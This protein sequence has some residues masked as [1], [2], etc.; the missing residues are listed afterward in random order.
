MGWKSLYFA[1]FGWGVVD[2]SD[3]V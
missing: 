2:G 1:G 3:Y